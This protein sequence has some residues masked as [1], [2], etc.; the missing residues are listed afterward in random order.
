MYNK[1]DKVALICCSNGLLKEERQTVFLLTKKLEEMGLIP[2]HSPYLYQKGSVFSGT[3]KERAAILMDYYRDPDIKAIFDI[4][5]GDLANEVLDYLDFSIIKAHPKL[6]FG[7]SDLTTILNAICVKTGQ[8]A[9]LF[10]LRNLLEKEQEQNFKQTFLDGGRALFQFDYKFLQGT[11]MEGMII[12]GNIRCL[13]KLAG[14]EFWPDMR[15]KVLFLESNGG[16]VPQMSAY[17]HQLR[18]IG[19]FEQ[20]NGI[21]LGTFTRMEQKDLRPSF[22]SMLKE[23]VKPSLP[24]A[25]TSQIGHGKDSKCLMLGMRII[26]DKKSNRLF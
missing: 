20:V 19:V 23:A 6:F 3:G 8:P 17:I 16:E 10:Q 15:E 22:Y 26:L 13:L 1:N 14:T 21:L 18:Q 7:Y 9:G 24:V 25:K 4:S 11:E 2:V 5:G 12:G